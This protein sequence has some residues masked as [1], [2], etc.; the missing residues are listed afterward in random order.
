VVLTSKEG[1]ATRL[2]GGGGGGG[3]ASLTVTWRVVVAGAPSSSV[4]RRPTVKVPAPV[5]VRA[6]VVPVPSS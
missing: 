3:G 1:L 2:P 4:T 6:A 5:K